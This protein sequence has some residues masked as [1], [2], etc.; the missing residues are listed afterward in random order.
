MDVSD[1]L[2]VQHVMLKKVAIA[3]GYA[4]SNSYVANF[5]MG[6]VQ[7]AACSTTALYLT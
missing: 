7:S 5:K 1:I 2:P 6:R 4:V 3:G